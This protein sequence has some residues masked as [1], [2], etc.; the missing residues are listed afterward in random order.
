MY[1]QSEF[2][3]R[4]TT[5][6][7]IAELTNAVRTLAPDGT[8]VSVPLVD[9]SSMSVTTSWTACRGGSY[10]ERVIVRFTDLV[11]NLTWTTI[12]QHNIPHKRRLTAQTDGAAMALAIINQINAETQVKLQMAIALNGSPN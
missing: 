9:M 8:V 12:F 10:C 3:D 4:R 2:L 7:R 6:L 5:L 1:E 11:A